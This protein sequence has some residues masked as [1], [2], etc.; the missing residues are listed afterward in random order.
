LDLSAFD[1]DSL[2]N[3]LL[4]VLGSM[5]NGY[6]SGVGQPQTSSWALW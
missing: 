6:S 4:A 3:V 2:I 1:P 5:S